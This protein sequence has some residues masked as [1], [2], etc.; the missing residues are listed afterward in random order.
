MYL[1]AQKF[2]KRVY[3]TLLPS[4]VVPRCSNIW[5]KRENSTMKFIIVSSF[6][7]SL[8]TMRKIPL[9]CILRHVSTVSKYL[10]VCFTSLFLDEHCIESKTMSGQ[11]IRATSTKRTHNR[12]EGVDQSRIFIFLNFVYPTHTQV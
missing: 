8:W 2:N 10:N 11:K 3:D 5:L 9:H 1:N 12:G 4:K 6:G 7:C